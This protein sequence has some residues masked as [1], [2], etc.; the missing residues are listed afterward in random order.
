MMKF[1][2][3]FSS[4]LIVTL[5]VGAQSA[6]NWKTIEN[7][8]YQITYPS[9][10]QLDQSGRN[11]TEFIVLSKREKDDAFRE[12]VNLIAQDLS[13]Q[14]MNLESYV[15]LSESQ[16]KNSVRDSKIF[17]SELKTKNGLSFHNIVWSGF[18]TGK[19]LKF[20]QLFFIDD[21]IAYALTLT[22]EEKEYENYIAT[23]DQILNSFIL[24]K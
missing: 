24:K 13:N 6:P 17:K 14:I 15:A 4:L 3:L 18:L 20:K 2:N 22:C 10:W 9:T 21:N 12:N 11:K 19:R 16:I 8:R 1:L 7:D 23:G 5:A